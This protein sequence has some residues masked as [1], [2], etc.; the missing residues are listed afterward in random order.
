M[1]DNDDQ[2]GGDGG[3][4]VKVGLSGWSGGLQI[5]VDPMDCHDDEIFFIIST[6]SMIIIKEINVKTICLLVQEKMS[7]TRIE[8]I[9]T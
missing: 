9:N 5:S 3:G 6:V 1:I 8:K 4:G 7:L 2:L